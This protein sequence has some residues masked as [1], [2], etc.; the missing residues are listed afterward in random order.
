MASAEQRH[1]ATSYL[2]KA[3]EYLGSA[4]DNLTVGRYT[5]AAGDAIHA[6]I[7]AKDAIATALTG[8]TGKG[9]DHAT[10]A[11]ELRVALGVRDRAA[12]AEKSLRD[13]VAAKGAVEYGT[14]LI[15]AAKAEPL[16]RRARSLV[17][18]AEDVVRLGR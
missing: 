13:L 16:I 7:S 1:H 9:R 6:G 3:R 14:A 8:T 11:K 10:A 4:E 5:P 15:T 18:L 2:T 17:E 12:A